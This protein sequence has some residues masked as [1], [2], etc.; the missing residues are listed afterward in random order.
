[1]RLYLRVISASIHRKNKK[2]EQDIMLQ[3]HRILLLLVFLI[4]PLGTSLA[5]TF[6]GAISGNVTDTTGAAIAG[7][8]VQLVNDSTGLSRNQETTSSGDFSFSELPVGFYTLT[9]TREGFEV[10]KLQKVEVAVGKVTN[11]KITLGLAQT[12]ETVEVQATAATLETTS[13]TLNAVVS[14]RAVQEIPLN[15]RDFRTLLY[16]APGYTQSRSMNG[17]RANQNN[18]QIDGTDNNDFW[19]NSEAVNQGSISG[20]AG[21]TLPIE[22]IDQFNQQSAGGG[23]FGRNPGAMV[24]VALKS[25]TNQ[26]HGSTYYFNRNEYFAARSPFTPADSSG[27]L[28]NEQYG[29]SVGGPI[30]KNRLFF[31]TNYERQKY[32]IGNRVLATVPSD[33]WID[34]AREILSMYNVPENPVMLATYMNLWPERS[35]SAPATVS[36]FFSNDDNTGESNNGVIKLDYNLS[37]NHTLSGRAFMG[38]GEAAQYVGAGTSVY[39][40]Y[41]QVVP[42]R[43]HN[44]AAT[45]TSTLTPRLVNQV[46]VG[47]NYFKQTFDDA[48]HS[49][50]PP[51]WGFNTGVTDPA[52]FGS[53]TIGITGFDN[54]SVGITAQLGRTDVTGHITDN[55]SYNFG[56][57]ALKFGG[58]FRRAKLDVAYLREARGAFTFNG[59]AGPW[60]TARIDDSDPNSPLRFSVAERSIADFLAGYLRPG[61]GSIATGDPQR[62][63]YVNSYEGWA[64]DNW[65][66]TSLLN[67]NYGLRYAY[68]GRFHAAGNKPIAIFDPNA[69]GGLSVVGQNIDALYP[70]DY[71]N[72]APR[73]GFAFTP[74]RN[75]KWVIRGHYGVYYDIINGNLFVDNQ[76]GSDGGRGVSRQPIGPAP[77]FSVNSPGTGPLGQGPLVISPGQY[78][79]ASAAGQSEYAVY[80]VNQ[81]LAA[82][83]VQNFGVDTQFQMTR[84]VMLQV[85]YVGNQAR[86]LVYTH[87]INQIR[88]STDLADNT[89]R[90]Y[91][92][93]FPQFIGIT[94]IE[95]AANSRYNALQVSLRTTSWRNLSSQFSYSYG[96]AVDEMS[97]PRNVRPTD[98]YNRSFDRGNADF[99]YRHVFTGYVLYDVPQLGNRLPLLTKGWQ[100]NT[101]I[102]ADSGSPYSVFASG[103]FSNTRN[104]NDRADQIGDPFQGIAQP[105]SGVQW[106]NPVAF[107][108]PGAG[109][110]GTTRRNA[111]YG[112]SFTSVDFSIFKNFTIKENYSLQF[113]A[114][115]FN[116]FNRMNLANP[117]TRI[118]DNFGT[119]LSTRRGVDAPGIGLGEPRNVQFALKFLF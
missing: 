59:T 25:G 6:R 2:G 82:P 37:A 64:Q 3:F 81:N 30:L 111:F 12:R 31:F 107:D 47:L 95:T 58:E 76:A 62:V 72:F 103:D 89:R 46:L 55:I 92:S 108:N 14:Q 45:L 40:E 51:S 99:D 102:T 10:Q 20:I 53:P 116:V 85:A 84:N 98:N 75:S 115:I 74:S 22:S 4:L 52:N 28:R 113:R 101:Y 60:A 15:G 110:Y 96:H 34:R 26:F 114:E 42:S 50:N 87:N 32:V 112:P 73:F 1:M 118:G 43:Q 83:Y 13:S 90:P 39:R 36:N 109:T 66:V 70:A 33:A 56:R 8:K 97:A 41:F 93:M 29:F 7:A 77:V 27:K 69:P 48:D 88:P 38:T 71:N 94:E 44:F 104:G 119:I 91:Y 17:N 57:H 106:F 21:V 18:W 79:F 78:I 68:N 49:A 5:Q 61:N 65:Q 63:Y 9:I 67:I 86:K 80:T 117:S 23:D 54:G 11:Q 24:N 100:I 35:R 19:Q 16:L 105:I